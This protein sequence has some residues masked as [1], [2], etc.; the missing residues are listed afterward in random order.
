MTGM[1]GL[2]LARE[3]RIVE[4]LLIVALVVQI[5][6]WRRYWMERREEEEQ[7]RIER[8]VRY[9]TSLRNFERGLHHIEPRKCKSDTRE[10]TDD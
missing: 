1:L 9:L 3:L 8:E 5:A 4:F 7:R 6:F 10:T 2:D